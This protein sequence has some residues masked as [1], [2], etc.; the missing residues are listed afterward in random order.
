MYRKNVGGGAVK[1]GRVEESRM[2]E[3]E[4]ECQERGK[5]SSASK[6]H[7]EGTHGEKKKKK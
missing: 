2:G 3:P 7:P 1:E 6:V 4:R 5:K